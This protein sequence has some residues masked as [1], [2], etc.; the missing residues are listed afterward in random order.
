LVWCALCWKLIF[1]TSVWKEVDLCNVVE[2][3]EA[4]A[5]CSRVVM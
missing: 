3:L 5:K 2:E 4:N 1:N